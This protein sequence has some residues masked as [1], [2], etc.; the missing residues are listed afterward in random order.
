MI[1][2]ALKYLIRVPQIKVDGI[3]ALFQHSYE[4]KG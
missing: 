4:V 2:F 3:P 1:I